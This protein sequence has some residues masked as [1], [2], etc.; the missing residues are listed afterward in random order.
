V[1]GR[2][3]AATPAFLG[4]LAPAALIAGLVAS[5]AESADSAVGSVFGFGAALGDWEFLLA[6]L[7]FPILA[8]VFV[9][10]RRWRGRRRVPGS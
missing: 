2:H 8:L 4:A 6:A 5:P 1:S 3:R 7:A 9:L 10:A